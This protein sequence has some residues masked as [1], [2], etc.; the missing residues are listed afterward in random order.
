MISDLFEGSRCSCREEDHPCPGI[1]TILEPQ[2]KDLGSFVVRRLLP[3]VGRKMVGPFVFFDHLGPVAFAPGEGIDVRPHPHIGLA[4]VSYVFEGEIVHRD[5][6][7]E[8]QTIRANE[9]NLMT[10]GRGIVH[11]ERTGPELRNQ[12]HTL[13]A[14][15]LWLALPLEQE[16]CEPGFDHYDATRLPTLEVDGVRLRLLIGAAYGLSSEVR[17]YS[18][19]LYLEAT[20][21]AG[22]SL[23]L[24]DDVAERAVYLVS[25]TAQALEHRL[26]PHRMVIFD[27][28]A[29]VTVTAI[30]D[31]RL[32][33]I[34]GDPLG[35]R[36]VWW[37]LVASDKAL[38]E[39]AKS[40]WSDGRFPAVPGEIEFIP[41]PD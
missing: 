6:L 16:R 14:L 39:Q 27:T 7:G 3:A 12:G 5:S 34:G 11:S 22:A 25:G 29:D 9:I 26:E 33:L 23:R 15:Q 10:A 40:D 8:V 13:H 20:L 17:T 19:T 35:K 38:I 41:L 36:T 1:I 37:N 2:E 24:P 18:P 31:T 4:T 21:P 30:E 32:V 28:Q